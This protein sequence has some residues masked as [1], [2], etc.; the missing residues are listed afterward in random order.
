MAFHTKYQNTCTRIKQIAIITEAR[1]EK[2]AGKARVARLMRL[3]KVAKVAKRGESC[4]GGGRD[5][6]TLNF[7]MYLLALASLNFLKENITV[8]S[9]LIESTGW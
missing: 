2:V 7:I 6:L 3:S 4:D 1:V 9:M 5:C 8:V